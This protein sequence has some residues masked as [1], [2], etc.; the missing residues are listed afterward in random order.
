M[1]PSEQTEYEPVFFD[2]ECSGFNPLAKSSISSAKRDADT[3]VVC[4]GTMDNWR[5]ASGLDDVEM[6]I[7]CFHQIE[8]EYKL[9]D[10][11]NSQM[12]NV[13]SGIEGWYTDV[14]HKGDGDIVYPQRSGLDTEAILVTYNGRTFD[15][16]YLGARF[17]RYRLDPFPFGYRRLRL[18]CIKAFL[19]ERGHY[20]SQDD[21]A[22][23][24]GV[25]ADD[26]IT[27]KDVPKAWERGDKEKVITHCRTDVLDLMSIFF[28]KKRLMMN[29]FYDHYDMDR[30]AVFAEEGSI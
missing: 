8:G 7:R 25:K 11:L 28:K 12:V 1:S 2:I 29:H 13:V 10:V 20:I 19:K 4:I 21:I 6:D 16:G 17:A 30:E 23:E 27:G 24:L 5:T 22:E 14:E 9:L 18:D 15:H 3:Y 26:Q